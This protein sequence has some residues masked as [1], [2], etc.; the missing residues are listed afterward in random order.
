M[1]GAAK[2]SM[3][4][5]GRRVGLLAGA[6]RFPISF[7]EAARREGHHVYCVGVMGM[8]PPELRSICYSYVEAPLARIG[9]AIT[10]FKKARIN[11]STSGEGGIQQ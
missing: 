6:G 10:L 8:A 9:R 2:S 7:A 5:G 4:P 11:H 1:D 3:K